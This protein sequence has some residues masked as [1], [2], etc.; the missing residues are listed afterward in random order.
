MKKGRQ[1]EKEKCKE[2][3]SGWRPSL[4]LGK[5]GQDSHCGFAPSSSLL[6]YF[7][8]SRK[9][10][11]FLKAF[12]MWLP[13]HKVY[14]HTLQMLEQLDLYV[15]VCMHIYIHCRH[16]ACLLRHNMLKHPW[17]MHTRTSL[18]VW[19]DGRTQREREQE[20]TWTLKD[21]GAAF[22]KDAWC[23]LLRSWDERSLGALCAVARKN[24]LFI[25]NYYVICH[26]AERKIESLSFILHSI[27][28]WAKAIKC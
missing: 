6:L 27:G 24:T 16:G 9:L 14:I 26:R 20:R 3:E 13:G 5:T 17:R 15:C 23:T 25:N 12:V 28:T 2:K 1:K 7:S 22:S 18:N 21:R 10:N 19:K 4:R 8:S 11:N